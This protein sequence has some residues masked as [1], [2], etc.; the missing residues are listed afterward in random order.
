MEE[1]ILTKVL[2]PFALFIIMFGM[3]LSLVIDDFK[4]VLI[5]PK[6]VFIGMFNQLLFLPMLGLGLASLIPL[7]PEHAIGLMI[8]AAAP[9]G[10]TSNLF[11]HL[12]KG[13]TALSITLTAISSTVTLFTIPFIVNFSLMKFSAT[14]TEIYLDPVKT[15][16]QIFAITI[17]PVSIGMLVRAKQPAFATSSEKGFKT[18]SGVFLFLIVIAAILKE[19]AHIV[20][21]FIA[22]GP[23]TFALNAISM[24]FGFATASFLLSDRRQ[25]ISISMESGI[26]N[27]TLGILIAAT[28]LENPAMAIP[29]AIYSLVMFINGF[30]AIRLFA[31]QGNTLK[32]TA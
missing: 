24:L 14:S 17:L 19:R 13:D 12:A 8:I 11:T 21:S 25:G 9:G 15:M 27:G 31:R 20:E 2:L 7:Q 10:V 6:A 16:A 32:E 3:G 22:V 29:P 28:M 4:R 30:I 26:Q 1:S 5:F 23:A 18:F